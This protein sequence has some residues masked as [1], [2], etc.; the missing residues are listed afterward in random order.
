MSIFRAW[1]AAAVWDPCG[2]ASGSFQATGGHGEFTNTKYAKLGDMGSK[3]PKF[4]SGA[5]WKAGSVVETMWSLRTNHVRH[6]STPPSLVRAE[7]VL[8]L[9]HILLAG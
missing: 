8:T 3:L 9:R 5:V 1:F 6:F 7:A 2:R 4:P